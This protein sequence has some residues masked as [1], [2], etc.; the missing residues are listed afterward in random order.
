MMPDFHPVLWVWK[1]FLSRVLK[2]LKDSSHPVDLRRKFQ[3]PRE[4]TA[5]SLW[6]DIVPL[7]GQS[8][9]AAAM[10]ARLSHEGPEAAHEHKRS[11]LSCLPSEGMWRVV[12]HNTEVGCWEFIT[13]STSQIIKGA[14]HWKAERELAKE[15][16]Q[17]NFGWGGAGAGD[18]ATLRTEAGVEWRNPLS[19]LQET[20]WN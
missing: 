12:K 10:A 9:A 20:D 5:A 6:P 11:I 14:E 2:I 17:G 4:I 8:D 19:H 13:S 18:W 1:K 7:A 16:K 3:F 15:A